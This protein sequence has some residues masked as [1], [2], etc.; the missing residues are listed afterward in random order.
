MGSVDD[1]VVVEGR[2][3][4]EYEVAE[5]EQWAAVAAEAE[6]VLADELA[7]KEAA[8]ASANSKLSEWGLTPAEIAAILTP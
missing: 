3:M 1:C 5:R 8:R 6:Q 4:T 2:E 7:A